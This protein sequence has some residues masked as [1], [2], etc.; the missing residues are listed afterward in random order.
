MRSS[1]IAQHILA[2]YRHRARSEPR[3]RW[4]AARTRPAEAGTSRWVVGRKRILLPLQE[5][6]G[7][8]DIRVRRRR[9]CLGM[10]CIRS[11]GGVMT[12]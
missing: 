7:G 12:G 5:E 8:A 9:Q 11:A 4:V 1:V 2:Y 3:T 10:E 6:R